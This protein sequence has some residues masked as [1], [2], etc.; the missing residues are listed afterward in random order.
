MALI[1]QYT[2]AFK[3]AAKQHLEISY[4]KE[5]SCKAKK[6]KFIQPTHNRKHIT[7]MYNIMD[8]KSALA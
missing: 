6:K 2:K 1:K 8:F 4:L 5:T 7:Y 3:S